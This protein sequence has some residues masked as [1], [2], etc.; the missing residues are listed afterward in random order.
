MSHRQLALF[1]KEA[2]HRHTVSVHGVEV[3]VIQFRGHQVLAFRGTQADK[4]VDIVRDLWVRPR[5]STRLGWGH[6]GFMNGATRI[7]DLKLRDV[8]DKRKPILCTGHS[9]GGA[10]AQACALALRY[11][12][13][14]VKA[15]VGFGSPR[16]FAGARDWDETELHHYR[17]GN[18]IVPK[19]LPP[20]LIYRH[21]VVATNL[22][23]AE[24]AW[25]NW[26]DHDMDNYVRALRDRP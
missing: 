25:P 22:G 26:A 5:R 15:W 12:R 8:I 6:A 9:A 10:I 23:Q 4:L 24:K 18:D 21:P 20:G 2:Y 16:V 17:F 19:W 11:H 1:A 13:Y 3:L 7:L 14:H